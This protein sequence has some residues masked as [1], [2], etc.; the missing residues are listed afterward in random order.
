MMEFKIKTTGD[1]I[2]PAELRSLSDAGWELV[3]ESWIHGNDTRQ[4][5]WRYI[6]RRRRL[7]AEGD[8]E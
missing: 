5:H 1:P 4:D 6:F 7:D 3:T 2:D 8:A